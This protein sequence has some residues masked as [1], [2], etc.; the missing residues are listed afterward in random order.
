MQAKERAVVKSRMVAVQEGSCQRVC[1]SSILS[2]IIIHHC[3]LCRLGCLAVVLPS[4]V[5]FLLIIQLCITD[6]FLALFSYRLLLLLGFVPPPPTYLT[7]NI[8]SFE[9]IQHVL[10]CLPMSIPNTKSHR[11]Y[12][13]YGH[14][15]LQHLSRYGTASFLFP[16][17]KGK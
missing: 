9:P 15:F 17:W 11:S 4:V 1:G 6:I 2:H 3:I 7:T 5:C 10:L 16:R 13:S 8:R 12:R 14:P